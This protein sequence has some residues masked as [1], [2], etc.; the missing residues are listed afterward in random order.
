LLGSRAL[1]FEQELI[2]LF[3]RPAWAWYR[4][5]QQTREMV[6]E[7][8][9]LL[10]WLATLMIVLAVPTF[11]ALVFFKR[12]PYGRYVTEGKGYGFE[13]NGKL[14]WVLQ[15][16]PCPIFAVINFLLAREACLN[17]TPN[18][19]L[20][21]LYALHYF[22]RC[23]ARVCSFV[24]LVCLWRKAPFPHLSCTLVRAWKACLAHV[25]SADYLYTMEQSR[26]GGWVG[27]TGC[28]KFGPNDRFAA[29]THKHDSTFVFPFKLRGGKPTPFL[30]FLGALVF[31]II[32]G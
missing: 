23:E 4:T 19:I 20:L 26:L 17:S 5:P 11:I 7:E 32:N 30:V 24:S 3:A 29:L 25:F 12:A 21:G 16:S 8:A 13:M 10:P 2:E 22:H 9:V 15:E 18:M 1:Q 31:C 14:A 6:V 27:E 28:W